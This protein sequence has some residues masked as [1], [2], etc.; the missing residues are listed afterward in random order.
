MDLI[1]E[2]LDAELLNDPPT[3]HTAVEDV[4]VGAMGAQNAHA[5][6]QDAASC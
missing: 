6:F 4:V 5:L 1:R 2:E 3:L